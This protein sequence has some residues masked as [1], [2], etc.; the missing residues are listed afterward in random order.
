[1]IDTVTIK[2]K[3]G[4]GGDGRVSFLR[5]KFKP[6]SGPDGGDGGKGGDIIFLADENIHTLR[7]FRSNPSVVAKDGEMGKKLKMYGKDGE[8][9]IVK[10]PIGTLVYEVRRGSEVLVG[11]FIVQGQSQ[12]MAKG[13]S[14]GKGNFRFR[15]SVNQVPLQFIRGGESVEKELKLEI[16]MVA[17]CGIIGLPNAGKSTFI[18]QV[19]KASAK[20]GNYPFTTLEPNL[21]VCVLPYQKIVFADI[22]GLIEGA[23]EGKGLGDD[24][25][26]HVERNKV[27][28]HLI[29]PTFD[30]HKN[31]LLDNLTEESLI[32]SS[33][34]NYEVI[35]KELL[36]YKSKYQSLIEKQEIIVINKIDITEVREVFS[37]IKQK[38]N[39]IGLDVYGISAFTGEGV[40]ELLAKISNVVKDSPE[41]KF[42]NKSPVKIIHIEDLKNRRM[43][44]NVSDISEAKKDTAAL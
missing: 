7:D 41:I 21:G 15:S 1:M 17:D 27:L 3:S 43:V 32:F 33:V 16:K 24:F 22:P 4:K 38:F 20:I 6:N 31:G 11:D 35:R 13:G 36:G 26:R 30:I 39:E 18:N 2:I 29:D 28:L 23:S 9:L 34:K 12:V 10:I 8:D 44:Y 40:P 14:G 37:K 25:L 42:E 5:E 19:T